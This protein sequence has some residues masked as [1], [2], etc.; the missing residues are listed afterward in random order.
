MRLNTN[1]FPFSSLADGNCMLSSLSILLVGHNGLV[2]KLRVLCSL[3][4]YL[5]NEFYASHPFFED[6]FQ[7]NKDLFCKPSYLFQISLSHSTTDTD[8]VPVTLIWLN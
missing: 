7:A 4:L 2:D 3:E 8:V 5:N 1:S 6:T